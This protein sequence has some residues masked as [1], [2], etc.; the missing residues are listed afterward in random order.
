MFDKDHSSK[1]LK[2]FEDAAEQLSPSNPQEEGES[3]VTSGETP[4][5]RKSSSVTTPQ[6]QCGR[7]TSSS[8][9]RIKEAQDND[10]GSRIHPGEEDNSMPWLSASPFPHNQSP[11]NRLGFPDTDSL[12]LQ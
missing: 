2:L 5:I 11:T 7:S 12:I 3:T 9:R 6:E 8:R 1:L 4:F 10:T